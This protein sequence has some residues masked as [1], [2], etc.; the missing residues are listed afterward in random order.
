MMSTRVAGLLIPD[1]QS[2]PVGLVPAAGH[3]RRLGSLLSGSKEV[4]PIGGR[5][6]IDYLLERMRAAGCTE[7]RV[8]TRPEKLDV[9]EHARVSGATV[10]LARPAS[11]SASLLAGVEDL[12]AETAVVFGF[13]DTLWQPRDGFVRLLAALGPGVAVA[14]GIFRA[15]DPER[16]D[17]VIL[18]GGRVAAIEVKPERPGSDLVW[19]CAAT[20]VS[21]LRGLEGCEEPGHFF[22]ELARRGLVRGVRLSDPFVD[23]GTPEALRRARKRSLKGGADR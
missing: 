16:S 10:V 3:A 14:L 1:G 19:G 6:V 21:V 23:I 7:I 22:G 20:R 13:P 2:L 15:E 17:I 12:D 11:V 18:E 8:V 9:V 5:P 4:Y